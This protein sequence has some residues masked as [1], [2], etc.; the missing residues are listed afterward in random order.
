VLWFRLPKTLISIDQHA[1]LMVIAA[2]SALVL[3]ICGLRLRLRVKDLALLLQQ[4]EER[5]RHLAQHDSL[6][7]LISRA[8]L[9]ER[10]NDELEVARRR[11]RPLALLMIDVDRFKQINDSLGHAAGDEILRVTAERI[12]SA[13]RE[14]DT[15][16]R[17]SGDEFVVLLPGVRGLR[18]AG[19]IAAQVV[20]SAACPVKFRGYEIPVSVSIGVSSYPAGCDDATS[21]L[22]NA[23]VAM[24][25]A[26]SSGRNRYRFF[27]AEMGRPEGSNLEFHVSLNEALAK[28]EFEIHYQ[29]LVD[30]RSGQIAGVE[31][32]LRWR[33]GP[34]GLVMPGEFI[35]LAEES[36][37]I[38]PLG[39]WVLQES[40]R[41]VAQLEAELGRKLSLAVNISPR[42]MEDGDPV[43]A[44]AD[45]LSRAHRNPHDLEL[46]ITESLLINNSGHTQEIFQ[47]LRDIGVRLAIDDF[48]TGFAN[49]TYLTQFKMDRLKIDRSFVQHCLIDRNSATIVRMI[50]AMAHRLEV[51]V[52]AE[53]VE[54][55]EQYHFLREAECDF[56]Q[57]YYLSKPVPIEELMQTFP[58]GIEQKLTAYADALS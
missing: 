16:A 50:I 38:I 26:K 9:Q 54:T 28:E 30:L 35:S 20:S 44:V 17:V 13:V 39:A 57:G 55:A 10:L 52:V 40:C 41:Q 56:A 23:D 19:G 7:G 53:G 3:L 49:L 32:L 12:R 37:L 58:A 48:G 24:Y 14:T 27:S 22:Q 31:A 6:T 45:A 42:Q 47:R 5:Y 4:S 36:G 18:E 51:A 11:Q 46:E 43:R 34:W 21:L 1:A 33:S 25:Q 15:V 2:L 29:P 8:L